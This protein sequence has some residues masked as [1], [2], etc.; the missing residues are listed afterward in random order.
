MKKATLLDYQDETEATIKLMQREIDG[1]RAQLRDQDHRLAGLRPN[2]AAV[3]PW[4]AMFE[5]RLDI[6]AAE[7]ARLSQMIDPVGLGL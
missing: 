4:V 2:M 1:L 6:L 3:P 7:V 5:R